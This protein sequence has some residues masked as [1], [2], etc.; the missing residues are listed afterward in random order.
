MKQGKISSVSLLNL[1]MNED[2]ME[3]EHAKALVIAKNDQDHGSRNAMMV[4]P[5]NS[6]SPSTD[7]GRD[8]WTNKVEFLL[9]IVGY[10][11]DLGKG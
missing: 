2:P 8:L 1:E 10:V 5:V 4:D 11:V 6:D 9:S 7:M 3:R